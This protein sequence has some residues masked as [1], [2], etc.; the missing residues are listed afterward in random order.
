MHLSGFIKPVPDF[1]TIIDKGSPKFKIP[2]DN[3]LEIPFPTTAVFENS[4]SNQFPVFNNRIY[5]C[6][7]SI[8]LS[9]HL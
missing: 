7:R 3:F 8:I 1:G 4:L 2:K 9:Q 6:N 5:A